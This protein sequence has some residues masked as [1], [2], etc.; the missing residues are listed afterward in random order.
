MN[1]EAIITTIKKL[2]LPFTTKALPI[3][4]DIQQ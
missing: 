4:M 1:I 2:S 3:R